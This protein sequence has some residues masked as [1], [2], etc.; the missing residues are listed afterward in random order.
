MEF[1]ANPESMQIWCDVTGAAPLRQSLSEA[2]IAGNPSEAP[3]IIDAISAGVGSAKVS[4]SNSVFNFVAE[5]VEKVFY[6]R[7]TV[8]EALD[9]A[10][11][12]LEE[13]IAFQ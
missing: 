4:Y 1:M 11:E 12:K 8:Q 9:A 5:A 3:Y 7:A 6:E 10:A 2:Y 13:E